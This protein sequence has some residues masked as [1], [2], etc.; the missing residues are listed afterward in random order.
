MQWSITMRPHT[1]G[2]MYGC[3][4]VKTYFYNLAKRRDVND[5][6]AKSPYPGAILL[7]GI[8]GGGKTTAAKIIAQMISCEHPKANGDPCCECPS[9]K[10]IINETFD[11]D[12]IQIDGGQT[13]KD[14]IIDTVTNFISKPA[15][16][17]N[18]QKVVIMEE[19]QELST[20]AKNALLKILEKPKDNIHFIFTS[21]EK[22]PASGISS[23]CVPFLFKPAGMSDVMFFLK[24]LL[25]K[26][27]TWN[28]ANYLKGADPI[29]FW[30]PIIQTIATNANGSYRQATQLMEQCVTAEAF[31][32]EQLREITGLVDMDT[33][34]ETL[35]DVLNGNPSEG[36]VNNLL[37]GDYQ[38]TFGLAY[39]VVA[40]A[41]MYKTFGR[42]LGQNS[43]FERQAAGLANHPNFEKLCTT[44]K[45][46][47][48]KGGKYLNKSDYIIE[49]C[50]LIE[51]CK[52]P[53]LAE[54]APVRQV[55]HTK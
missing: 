35:T 26:T 55:R 14:E 46:L 9:C 43:Y 28:D 51:S 23:R 13:G 21:M 4:G 44:Y 53:R 10:A 45:S 2:E 49:M 32:V 39:K 37:E 5:V 38:K 19:I 42:V 12:C 1:F 36:V 17:G 34:Y 52:A 27:G 30:G 16:R 24:D 40:D 41:A 47:S 33:W 18:L 15:Y 48:E 8:F 29:Q 6:K 54:T 50:N 22:L 3:D 7:Q 25:E 11:R 20:K 31:T